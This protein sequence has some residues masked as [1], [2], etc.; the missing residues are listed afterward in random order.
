M[1]YCDTGTITQPHSSE[2]KRGGG[3]GRGGG[4]GGMGEVYLM[5]GV[6]KGRGGVSLP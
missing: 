5:V 3:R 6:P 2:D 1:M 4:N